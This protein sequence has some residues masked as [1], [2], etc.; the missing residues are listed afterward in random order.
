MKSVIHFGIILLISCLLWG[1]GFKTV[2]RDVK[3]IVSQSE[4]VLVAS[5][6]KY[7]WT[8]QEILFQRADT[9]AS[10]CIGDKLVLDGGRIEKKGDLGDVVLVFRSP[11][12]IEDSAKF[13]ENAHDVVQE[14][15]RVA[16]FSKSL[17]EIRKIIEVNFPSP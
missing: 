2:E 3:K 16:G 10:I 1:C 13:F 12:S 8:V 6:E 4:V 5:L 9:E 7:G 17:A 11:G 15:R 14:G